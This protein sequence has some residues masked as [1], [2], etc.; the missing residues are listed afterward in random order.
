[1]RRTFPI[2][3]MAVAMSGC[4]VGPNYKRPA[5]PAP[6]AFRAGESQPTAA[7]LGDA[8]WFDV[9]Q[10]DALRDLVREA[11]AANY[12]VLIA[13][14][15]VLQAQGQVSATRSAIFPEINAQAASQGYG[16]QSP[17]QRTHYGFYSASWEPDLFGKLRRATEAARADLLALDENRKGVMQALVA[18]VATAY[19]DLRE[20]DAELEYVRESL[21]ARE[22]SVKLV[23]AR[24]EGGVASMLELDQ[25]KS[26]VASAQSQAALL[27]KVQEQ[28][29]NVINFLIGKEPGP[30]KRGNA[31][32]NQPQPPQIP[33][34][35]P[36]ALLERRPDL[37][38]A[39]QRL[40]AANARVGVAKAAFYPSI[41]L[42]A[43]GGLQ[44]TD[45]L[46]V[47][48]RAGGAWSRVATLDIPIFDMGRR[49][50]NYHTAQAQREEMVITYRKAIN[51]AFQDVSNALVGYQ[52]NREYSA[53]QMIFA[54]TLRDQSRLAN[55]RYVGGV[56]SYLEVL[57]TERQRLTAEQQLAQAQRDV[58]TSLVQLYKALGGGWQ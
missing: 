35:L 2:V 29:E 23:A 20:Y 18:Q 40:V 43:G 22:Q 53:S 57:D 1:M 56:S 54:E 37:R 5:V 42:T 9:F 32:V 47:V 28:T 33:A 41:S 39:E 13:A 55:V 25:A 45:L 51:G 21:A 58:L 19:F 15:R 34:G 26:L 11:L 44:S 50:G 8:K 31:L 36:S 7:S 14:Q 16:V 27:E 4:M 17:I 52:K 24:E 48:N 38:E 3:C 12:D 6:P 10:D 46:S 49:V 30:V